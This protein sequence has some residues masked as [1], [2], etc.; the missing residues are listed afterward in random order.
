LNADILLHPY[1]EELKRII[2][3]FARLLKEV[4]ETVDRFGLK[5]HFL[6]RHCNSGSR[7][8]GEME[9]TDVQS[10]AALKCKQRFEKNRDK[11]FTFLDY[12]GV[13]W[14]NNNAE[15]AIKAF[16]ALRAGI[17]GSSSENGTE[18]YLI[19]LSVCQTCK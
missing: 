14:N 6:H 10:E 5:K 19:L 7:F 18:D 1:D 11:L 9:S 17:R 4:V 8:Y 16:A 2:N 15:H 12:D 13:P 3:G